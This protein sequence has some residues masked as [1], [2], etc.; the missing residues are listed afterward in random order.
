MEKRNECHLRS[1]RPALQLQYAA[2]TI[3]HGLSSL[4]SHARGKSGKKRSSHPPAMCDTLCE[5]CS[6]KCLDV[7]TQC[8]VCLHLVCPEAGIHP[9]SSRAAAL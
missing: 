2:G 3:L 1:A 7:Q 5:D 8:E 4:D 6:F 9:P